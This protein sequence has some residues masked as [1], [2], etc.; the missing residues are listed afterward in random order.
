M[1]G[2]QMRTISAVL[3]L[4]IALSLSA[5]AQCQVEWSY[6]VEGVSHIGALAYTG[7]F[8][9]N[10]DYN[11]DGIAEILIYYS[12]EDQ[13]N[14]LVVDGRSHQELFRLQNTSTPYP[15]I[16]LDSDPEPEFITWESDLIEIRS[17]VDGTVEW[18]ERNL[19]GITNVGHFDDFDNDSRIEF[20]VT[21]FN[22]NIGTVY[23]YGYPGRGE[24]VK[25]GDD[26][27]FPNETGLTAG[28]NPFNNNTVVKFVSESQSEAE[29]TIVD[30]TGRI[31]ICDARY[32]LK[33]GENNLTLSSILPGY[34]SLPGGAYIL[35]INADGQN[36]TI[37]LVKLP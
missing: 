36:S 28:P 34:N 35:R 9:G 7:S 3:L 11:G 23:V 32:Q 25:E 17:G 26:H 18:T 27:S 4:V 33:A 20:L 19:T 29:L 5:H 22:D 2:N 37:N 14:Y 15:L 6:E 24:G 12:S 16:N 21:T 8:Y 1:K 10:S 31:L 30:Q 13:L